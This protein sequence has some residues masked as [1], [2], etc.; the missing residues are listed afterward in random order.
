MLCKNLYK[1]VFQDLFSSLELFDKIWMGHVPFTIMGLADNSGL[2]SIQMTW[3][4]QVGK[5]SFA[6]VVH[7]VLPKIFQII[8]GLDVADEV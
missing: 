4:N 5:S 6:V 8:V 7:H 1:K 2:T 3:T